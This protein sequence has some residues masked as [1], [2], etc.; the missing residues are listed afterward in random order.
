MLE[1]GW[2]L[3]D[4]HRAQRLQSCKVTVNNTP[5]GNT[6]WYRSR[7]SPERVPDWELCAGTGA[8][9]QWGC[10]RAEEDGWSPSGE[11]TTELTETMQKREIN[12]LHMILGL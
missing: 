6:V 12:M 8:E 1:D 10:W 7:P 4:I 2:R 11:R 5:D 9:S 3:K